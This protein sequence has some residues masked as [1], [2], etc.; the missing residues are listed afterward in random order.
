VVLSAASVVILAGSMSL[1]QIVL[2]QN[3]PYILLQPLGFLLF[4]I[5][6]CAEINRSP[7]DLLEADSEIVAGYH[8]E[9]SGMKYLAFMIAEYSEALAMSAIIATFFLAG[10]KGPLLPPWL[11]LI[12]KIFA[13]FFVMIWLRGTLPR[14][15]IDQ[16]MALAWKF[17][18]PLAILN[19]IITG[20]EV[21]V[22]PAGL[23]WVAVPINFAITA[24]L[25]L[26]WSRLYKFGWGRVEVHRVEQS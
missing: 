21:L 7:F 25:I 9:Y 11:W 26:L 17:L 19:L 15:R 10:W 2:A 4:F 3:I 24:V 1:N 14:V 20:V 5:S 18:F 22:W 13:V 8:T 6:G 16:L 12:V 23:P